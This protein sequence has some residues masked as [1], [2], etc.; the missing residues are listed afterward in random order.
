MLRVSAVDRLTHFALRARGGDEQALES[1]VEAT[2]DEVWRLCASLVDAQSADD[3]AQETFVR[4][5]RALRS[6]RGEA[7]ARTWLLSIARH[8]CSDEVRSMIRRRRRD[9]HLLEK[10]R[11]GSVPDASHSAGWLDLVSGLEPD[12]RAAFVLTQVLGLSYEEAARVCECPL[13]T[14]RSRVARARKQ[15]IGQLQQ[16]DLE[17]PRPAKP[18]TLGGC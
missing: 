14:I 18:T 4:A 15:L 1:F 7:S 11:E 9:S 8:T 13:G 5:V 10:R 17:R 3:I 6:F 2:Y 12:R 16:S